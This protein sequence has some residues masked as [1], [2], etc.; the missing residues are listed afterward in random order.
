MSGVSLS[1]SA[2]SVGAPTTCSFNLAGGIPSSGKVTVGL[3][4]LEEAPKSD[5]APVYDKQ[6]TYLRSETINEGGTDVKY[7]IYEMTVTDAG[8]SIKLVAFEKGTG[9]IKLWADEYDTSTTTITIN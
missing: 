1:P 5:V 7:D 4:R 9:Y 2:I 3:A 6:L 8:N